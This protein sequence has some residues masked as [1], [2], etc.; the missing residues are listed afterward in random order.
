MVGRERV[1]DVLYVQQSSC[2]LCSR[3]LLSFLVCYL[4]LHVVLDNLAEAVVQRHW[5]ECWCQTRLQDSK[6]SVPQPSEAPPA[7]QLSVEAKALRARLILGLKRT[8]DAA[9][10]LDGARD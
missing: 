3:V 8:P 9:N 2:A 10:E 5:N 1:A 4:R 6:F 7:S